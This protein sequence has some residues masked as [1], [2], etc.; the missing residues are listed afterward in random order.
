MGWVEDNSVILIDNIECKYKD[1][2]SYFKLALDD[3][4]H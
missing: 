1:W 3:E 2:H 4:K